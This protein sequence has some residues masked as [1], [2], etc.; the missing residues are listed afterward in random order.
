MFSL[1]KMDQFLKPLN[2]LDAIN[3][4]MLQYCIVVASYNCPSHPLV[5][6]HILI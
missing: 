2:V 6:M 4:K 1:V 5:P 3:G